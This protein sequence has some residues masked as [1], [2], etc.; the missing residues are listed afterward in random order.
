MVLV[1]AVRFVKT[2]HAVLVQRFMAVPV[3]IATISSYF[4]S[5]FGTAILAMRDAVGLRLCAGVVRLQQDGELDY[6]D[7]SPAPSASSDSQGCHG[8][9]PGD[10]ASGDSGSRKIPVRAVHRK[11]TTF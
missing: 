10:S 9:I 4:H 11:K 8:S 7:Q 6:E 3:G 1:H 2:G 5:N